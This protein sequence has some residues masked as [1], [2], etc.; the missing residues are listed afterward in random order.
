MT[1]KADTIAEADATVVYA[2]AAFDAAARRLEDAQRART[3]VANQ[4]RDDAAKVEA[5]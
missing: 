5:R 4:L 1:R 3:E 2:R